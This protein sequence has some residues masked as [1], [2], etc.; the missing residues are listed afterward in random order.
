[1]LIPLAALVLALPLAPPDS[2]PAA[3]SNDNRVP[4]GPLVAPR[5]EGRLAH[6]AVALAPA[7]GSVVRRDRRD[8]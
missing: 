5:G 1:M 8:G 2:V 7:S 4:A 6:R 3:L